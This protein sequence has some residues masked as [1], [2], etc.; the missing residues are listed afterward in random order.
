MK[1]MDKNISAVSIQY[2]GIRLQVV[3]PKTLMS[4]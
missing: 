3:K 4:E 2:A 1:T